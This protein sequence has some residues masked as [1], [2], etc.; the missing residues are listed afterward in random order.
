MNKAKFAVLGQVLKRQR[1][2][3]S[4]S[5]RELA[6]SAGVKPSY[7]AYIEG[8]MRRPSLP[9]LRRITDAL[10]L[11]RQQVFLL[12]YPEA[13]SMLADGNESRPVGGAEQAWRQFAKNRAVL[14]SHEVAPNEMAVLKNIH[15]YWR[16]PSSLHFLLLLHALR[17]AVRGVEVGVPMGCPPSG[18]QKRPR[19]SNLR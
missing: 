2:A 14:R 18:R 7:V 9:V 6:R 11:N 10:G 19:R 16:V 1:K 3:L 4:L 5:Q 13:K 17:Q 15:L 8:G 12:A